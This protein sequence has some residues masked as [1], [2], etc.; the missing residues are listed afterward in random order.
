MEKKKRKLKKGVFLLLIVILTIAIYSAIVYF[1]LGTNIRN[2]YIYDNNLIPDW[3]I[4]EE[5]GL[6][7]YPNFYTTITHN[8]EKKLEKD[9]FIKKIKV[10]KHFFHKIYIY[11]TEYKIL[12]YYPEDRMYTLEDGTKLTYEYDLINV[13]TL[14]NYIPND[15][16]DNFVV[17][18][19]K[20][21]NSILEKIS[22][23]KYDPSEYDESRFLLYM[24]DGNYV[25]VTTTKLSLLNKY[26]ETI[27]KLEGK[28]GILY[29]DS[30]N[31]FEIKG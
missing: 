9:P 1:F 24:N 13:P 12:F 23:I 3:Y 11:V 17:G 6:K 31:Y 19:S 27:K 28:E 14:I 22:E 8:I 25:Y 5:A 21:N 29:L 16:Y 10:E 7:N 2:I 26:N 4:I 30:G 18:L 15:Q 20:I